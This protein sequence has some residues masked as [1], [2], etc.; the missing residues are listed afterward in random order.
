MSSTLF[1][2]RLHSLFSFISQTKTPVICAFLRAQ[3]R[4]CRVIF[5]NFHTPWQGIRQYP[6]W[7]IFTEHSI[8][9]DFRF[10]V[11]FPKNTCRPLLQTRNHCR[12]VQIDY[13]N[14]GTA[15]ISLFQCFFLTIGI[16]RRIGIPSR[17][18]RAACC[19]AFCHSAKAIGDNVPAQQKVLIL[20]LYICF[21]RSPPKLNPPRVAIL[22]AGTTSIRGLNIS[23]A[24]SSTVI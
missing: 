19:T 5:Q 6:L 23:P 8:Q 4:I 1:S 17:F 12:T 15:S 10:G 16:F 14:G 11:E 2:E 20:L 21:T 13:N 7:R 18:F 24:F 22:S 3:R 9:Q